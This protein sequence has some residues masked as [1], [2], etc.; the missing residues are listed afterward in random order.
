MT[1][2]AT[3]L[4]LAALAVAASGCGDDG[5]GGATDGGAAAD[6]DALVGTA[7]RLVPGGD[8]WQAAELPT[9]EF[10]ADGRATGSAGCNRFGGDYTVDG[11][12]L[13]LGEL[14]STLIGCEPAV[15][16]AER[17]YLDTLARVARWEIDGERLTL[18]DADGEP[19]LTFR[20]AEPVGD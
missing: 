12:T 1:R 6:R 2:L 9:I 13:E 4:A 17:G 3:L 10:G 11:D 18:A 20:P 14:A 15:M 5:G 8:E 19:L 7:W 16:E